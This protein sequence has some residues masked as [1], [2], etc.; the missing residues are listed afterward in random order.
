MIRHEI[1][2]PSSNNHLLMIVTLYRYTLRERFASLTKKTNSLTQTTDILPRPTEHIYE[3]ILN[4]RYLNVNVISN[5]LS[6]RLIH[7]SQLTISSC[8]VF[9]SHNI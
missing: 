8:E 3:G 6:Y 1:L 7:A 2:I 9:N 5:L 4:T